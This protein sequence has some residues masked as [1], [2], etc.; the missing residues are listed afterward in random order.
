MTDHND[1]ENVGKIRNQLEMGTCDTPTPTT[2][3]IIQPYSRNDRILSTTMTPQTLLSKI[4]P[5]E[6]GTG[7]ELD[8]KSILTGSHC[9]YRSTSSLIAMEFQ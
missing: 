7:N 4:P 8:E 5:F 3:N 6:S 9:S 1:D 2:T